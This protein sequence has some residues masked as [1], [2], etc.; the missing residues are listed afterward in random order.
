MRCGRSLADPPDDPVVVEAVGEVA[1]RLAALLEGAES[2]QPEQLFQEGPD[3][4]LGAA[5]ALGLEDGPMRRPSPRNSAQMRG[6]P[7]MRLL[8]SNPAATC[9][10][11]TRS[12]RTR[13][14][15]PRTAPAW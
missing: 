15:F 12:W 10:E 4:S 14:H 11:S 1:E 13:S 5:I 3:E 6:L 8:H 7:H 9:T 2:V